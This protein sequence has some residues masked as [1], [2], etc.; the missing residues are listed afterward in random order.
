MSWSSLE[1]AKLAVAISTPL[2]VLAVGWWIKQRE[3]INGE[4]IRKRIAIYDEVVPKAN[5]IL[6]FFLG[7]GHWRE[8]DPEKVVACKRELDRKMHRYRPFWSAACWGRYNAFISACFEHFSGGAGRPARLRLDTAH[9]RKMIGEHFDPAWES[10]VSEQ[11]TP[12]KDVADAY[13][14]WVGQLAREIGVPPDAGA[15]ER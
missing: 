8:L 1:L 15:N 13:D 11:P 7:V 3:Q 6:C 10:I 12:W 2:T 4:L 9:L 5:D 14:A